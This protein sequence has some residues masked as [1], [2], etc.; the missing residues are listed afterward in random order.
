MI[1]RGGVAVNGLERSGSALGAATE[2]P[3]IPI[4]V[5]NIDIVLTGRPLLFCKARH[6]SG[7]S[8]CQVAEAHTNIG[9][10]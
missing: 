7:R 5:K 6:A 3:A 1:S 10:R 9:T 8:C 2:N 4:S